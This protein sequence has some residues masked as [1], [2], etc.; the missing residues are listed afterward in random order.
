MSEGKTI[1]NVN[2]LD[3]HKATEEAIA[4]IS[5]IGNVNVL[6][7]SPDTPHFADR[8]SMGNINTSIEVPADAE[9]RT[10]MGHLRLAPGSLQ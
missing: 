10:T 2:I 8:V 6:L 7:Y 4:G 5:R 3:L 1:G 9:L